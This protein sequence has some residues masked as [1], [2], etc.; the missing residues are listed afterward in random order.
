M[1]DRDRNDNFFNWLYDDDKDRDNYNGE[2]NERG[3]RGHADHDIE[4]SY[5]YGDGSPYEGRESATYG[6]ED[7][8][9]DSH[10]RERYR[11]NEEDPEV[12]EARLKAYVDTKIKKAKPKHRWLKAIA[13]ILVGAILGSFV[14]MYYPS[15]L[16][17]LGQAKPSTSTENTSQENKI[18]SVNI[19]TKEE[20][21]VES[22]V[23]K[24]ATPSVVGIT[25]NIKRSGGLFFEREVQGQSIGSGVIVS[26]DG[27][28][29]TNAHVVA[30]ASDTEGVEVLF[31]NNKKSNGRVLW[32]DTTLDLAIVK[33]EEKGLQAIELGDSS[34]VVVGDKAIAIG[35]PVGLN[36]QST[37]TSGY[38]S[39]LNRSISLEGGSILDGLFQTDAAINS[40]NS[41]GALL[42][43]EGKLIGINTAKVQSTDGIGFA[44]PINVAKPVIDSFIKSGSFTSVQLGI[45][46]I[47]LDVYKQYRQ[48]KP[49]YQ[50]YQ[51]VMVV[52]LQNRG[53]AQKAGLREGDII[54]SIN[55]NKVESMNSLKHNL[56]S[57]DEGDTTR[58][59]VLRDGKE[60]TIEVK[61]TSPGPNI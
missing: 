23:A 53:N 43:K 28:I 12:M 19:S 47:D 59:I 15:K 56:L 50:D 21:N 39:G 46:G 22:A 13:L 61:F 26:S 54:I 60:K 17:F 30:E 14:G 16:G 20:S 33:V 2:G 48:I 1:S 8:W 36:L 37:L 10:Y 7:D 31:Y 5:Y 49:E 9:D 35:N 29:L 3:D 58:L 38:I 55:G 27:Y 24:K 42:N 4:S 52:E 18:S 57:L 25:V 51:G 11:R 32:K 45:R 6:Q 41:G 34:K 44:I 40:G